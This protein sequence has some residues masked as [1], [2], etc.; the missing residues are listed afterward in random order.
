LTVQIE[1]DEWTLWLIGLRSY[2]VSE[3][4]IAAGDAIGAVGG[5]GSQT[6]GVHYAVYDKIAA[7]FVDALSFVP[8]ADCPPANR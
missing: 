5:A 6:P 1:N 2:T 3:G 7:G 8:A 4:T